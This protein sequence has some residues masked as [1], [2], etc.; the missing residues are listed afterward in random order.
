MIKLLVVLLIAFI[1][2]SC[3]TQQPFKPPEGTL[4]MEQ[5]YNRETQGKARELTLQPLQQENVEVRQASLNGALSWSGDVRRTVVRQKVEPLPAP[6][7]Q[8]KICVAPH[9]ATELNIKVDGYCSQ[10]PLYDHQ[11]ERL[12]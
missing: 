4:T 5:V 8:M 1:L 3:S 11:L 2:I 12:Y 10:V 7:K 6:R 9:F